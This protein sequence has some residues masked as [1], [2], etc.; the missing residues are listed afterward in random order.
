MIQMPLYYL[1]ILYLLL[2]IV[3]FRNWNVFTQMFCTVLFTFLWCHGL[4][5]YKYLQNKP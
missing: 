2:N 5:K 4:Q 3:V 1:N